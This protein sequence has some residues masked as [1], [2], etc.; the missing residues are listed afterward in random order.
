MDTFIV[1][2]QGGPSERVKMIRHHFQSI[3]ELF[4]ANNS[5]Y[6]ENEEPISLNKLTEP[7]YL[8][9]STLNAT[10]IVAC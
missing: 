3:D 2:V 6:V 10:Q 5:M 1:V 7:I 4:W 8:S 9:S